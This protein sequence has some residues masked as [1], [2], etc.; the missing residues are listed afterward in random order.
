MSDKP[1][2]PFDGDPFDGEFAAV[3]EVNR[4]DEA[5]DFTQRQKDYL[6]R[7]ANAYKAVFRPGERSQSDIDIV[8]KDMALFCRAMTTRYDPEQKKQDMLEGRAEVFYRIKEHV[9]LTLDE[10]FRLYTDAKLNQGR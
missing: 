6:E 4:F 7:R 5:A 10:L 2:D 1:I 9:G 8:L 3:V